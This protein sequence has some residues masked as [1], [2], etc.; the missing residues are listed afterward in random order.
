MRRTAVALFLSFVVLTAPV[1]SACQHWQCRE[2]ETTATCYMF[3]C[4]G[5]ACNDSIYA[6][7]YP[8]T[9][10]YMSGGGCFCDPEGMCYD[11]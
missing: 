10:D 4:N 2:S 8:V 6:A 1:A 7:R 9:C 11:I 3:F 5:S